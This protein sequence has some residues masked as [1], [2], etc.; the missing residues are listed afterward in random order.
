MRAPWKVLFYHLHSQQGTARRYSYGVSVLHPV[1]AVMYLTHV[2][3][4]WVPGLFQLGLAWENCALQTSA[5]L[6]KCSA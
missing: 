5:C 2:L 1:H 3:P 4:R 6:M